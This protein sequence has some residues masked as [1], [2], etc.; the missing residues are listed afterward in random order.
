MGV[1]ITVECSNCSFKQSFLLGVGKGYSSLEL[2]L[3]FLQ[4]EHKK[5]IQQ[6]LATHPVSETNYSHCLLLCENCNRLFNGFYVKLIFDSGQVYETMFHCSNCG[7]KL[8]RL[9]S[10]IEL[11]SV[12]CVNC[13]QKSLHV[14]EDFPWD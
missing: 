2:A 9:H 14:T 12:P 6:S 1:G 13:D 10:L 7:N 11:D 8:S 4:P 3:Q 5:Q